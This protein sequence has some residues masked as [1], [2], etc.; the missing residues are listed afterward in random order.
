MNFTLAHWLTPTASFYEVF[1]V[2][3]YTGLQRWGKAEPP[4]SSGE[5]G[6]DVHI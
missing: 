3:V 5:Q 6:W 2:G 1:V 4:A